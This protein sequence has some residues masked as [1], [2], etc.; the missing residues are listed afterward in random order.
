MG[1]DPLR[2]TIANMA[3]K[4]YKIKGKTKWTQNVTSP[5]EFRGASNYKVHLYDMDEANL[6]VWKESGV[7]TK[8]RIDSSGDTL[9]TLKRPAGKKIIKNEVVDFGPPEFVD[10]GGS[11]ITVQVANG[12]EVEVHYVTYDTNGFGKGHRVNKVVVTNLIEYIK[13]NPVDTTAFA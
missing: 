7:Q 12:S 2:R 6:A 11:P 13:E 10:A 3:T 8:P 9:Y 1:R 5:D 4:F